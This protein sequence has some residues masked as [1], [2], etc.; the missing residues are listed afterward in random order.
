[1]TL[2]YLANLEN[3]ENCY[4]YGKK[5]ISKAKLE[6]HLNLIGKNYTLSFANLVRGLVN[7]EDTNS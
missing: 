5:S 4:D 1:M 6:A 7:L 3:P 2:I